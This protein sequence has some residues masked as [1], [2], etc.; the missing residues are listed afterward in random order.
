MNIDSPGKSRNTS[1]VTHAV[2][3]GVLATAL[4]ALNPVPLR[5][6]P[7]PAAAKEEDLSKQ[8][9]GTWVYLGKPGETTETPAMGGRFKVMQ[10]GLYRVTQKDAQ[11][12]AIYHHGGTYTIQG[13][14][15]AEKCE[16]S[17]DPKSDLIKQQFRFTIKIEGDL[18]T[19][20][21]VDNPWTEVW[22][23]VK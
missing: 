17:S 15:Y 4:I 9:V 14:E 2:L 20:T 16:Y 8:I 19:Q 10:H 22:R 21:G 7:Q 1:K 12:A 11:G 3:A 13:N 5:A 6:Q 18:L 23:R